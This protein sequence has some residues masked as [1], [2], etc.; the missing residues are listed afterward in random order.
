MW[1]EDQFGLK[2]RKYSGLITFYQ[3]ELQDR[4]ARLFTV[5]CGKNIKKCE[6]IRAG[7]REEHKLVELFV[8][9][10]DKIFLLSVQVPD[11]KRLI[12]NE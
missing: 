12:C 3:D 8:D 9:N 1:T 6:Q 5:F 11:I 2:S 7:N 10:V 4:P